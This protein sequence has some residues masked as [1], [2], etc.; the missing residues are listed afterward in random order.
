MDADQFLTCIIRPTLK[1]ISKHAPLIRNDSSVE[2]LLLGTAVHESGGLRW[3]K[4]LGGGDARSFYQIEEDTHEWMWDEYLARRTDLGD[5]LKSLAPKNFTDSNELLNDALYDMRYS[6][7][8]ARIR[9]I[10]IRERIPDTVGGQA[11]YWKKWWN[12]HVGKGT[13]TEYMA[14]W[15]RYVSKPRFP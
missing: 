5:I 11:M 10:P 8:V 15:Y 6:T 14:N 13:E 3:I 9:Y 4:Q 2:N 12:T 1:I 7:A